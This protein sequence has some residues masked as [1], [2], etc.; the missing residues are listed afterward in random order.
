MFAGKSAPSEEVPQETHLDRVLACNG[1]NCGFGGAVIGSDV[2][3]VPV[4]TNLNRPLSQMLINEDRQETANYGCSSP[5]LRRHLDVGL[6]ADSGPSS[7]HAL[8]RVVGLSRRSSIDLAMPG[9]RF[10][11]AIRRRQLQT[12]AAYPCDAQHQYF[13][14]QDID[15][16]TAEVLKETCL[17]SHR[18][19]RVEPA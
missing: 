8:R 14:Q 11:P 12:S 15:K 9:H 17:R 6:T 5:P 1:P 4:R 10:G 19:R 7:D 3:C 18:S 13:A 16:E 2:V